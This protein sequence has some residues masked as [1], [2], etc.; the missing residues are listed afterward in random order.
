MYASHAG[1]ILVIQSLL[2]KGVP[3]GTALVLL[4]SITALSFPEMIMLNRVLKWKLIGCFCAF[5]II[6]FI[7]TGYLLNMFI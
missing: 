3:L 1:V 7:I 2:G 4:M 5:L 6:S